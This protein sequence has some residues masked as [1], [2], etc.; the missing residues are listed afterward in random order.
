MMLFRRFAA[1]GLLLAVLSFSA[2]AQQPAAANQGSCAMPASLTISGQAN[3]FTDE[4]EEWLGDLIEKTFRQQF[5]VIEDPDGYLQKI[6]DRLLAQ[7]PPSKIHYRFYIVD[8]PELN[9]FGTVGG[10]IYLFRRVISFA[11]NEDE[12]AALLGHEI[13]HIATHQAAIEVSDFMR[14]LNVLKVGDRQDIANKWN[15]LVDNAAKIKVH[16]NEKQEQVIAD[17]VGLYAMARAGYDPNRAI[18]FLDRLF[19]TK[20]KTGGFWS[21]LFGRTSSDA[22]RL[23]EAMRNATAMSKNCIAPLPADSASAFANWQKS[24]VESK[25]SV[26]KEEVSG[27]LRKTSLNP[28]LRGDL[29][30]IHFSHDGA[31]IM[32][33]DES[34]IFLLTRD[35]LA[36]LFRIDAPDSSLAKFSPDMKSVVFYDK[37]YRVEKWDIPTQKRVS[38]HQVTLPMHCMQTTLSPT[39]DALAC[40]TNEFELQIIDVEKNSLAFSRKKF[41]QPNEFEAY[42]FE[43]LL[44]LG[45]PTEWFQMHFSPDG[46]YLVAGR[47]NT[48]LAYDLTTHSEVKLSGKTKNL[49]SHSFSFLGP[50][51]IAGVDYQGVKRKIMLA[52]F[53]TGETIGDVPAT[54]FGDMSPVAKGDYILMHNVGPENSSIGVLD[55]KT[56]TVLFGYKSPGFDIYDQWFAGESVGG[57]IGIFNMTDKKFVSHIRL[58]DSPLGYPRAVA[59]SS[60]GKW[61]ATS[62]PTR[63]AIWKLETGERMFYTLGFEG[64]FFDQD[65]FIGKFPKHEK[66]ASRVFQF[67]PND[68]SGKLLYAVSDD[69]ADTTAHQALPENFTWQL[70]ELLLSIGSDS[71]NRSA[72]LF[73]RVYDVRTKSKLWEHGLR[74]TRPEFFHSRAGKTLT[75]LVA[76]YSAIKAEAKD[77]PSLNARL[78]AIEGSEGKKDSY[79][80]RVFDSLTGKDLGA[81]LV[82]TGNLSFRVKWANTIKD[83]VLVGDSSNRTLV[84]SL[85]SG[86]QKGKVFGYPRAISNDA[87]KMLVEGNAGTAD[88]YDIATLAPLAHFTFPSRIINAE[89]TGDGTTLMVLTADQTVYQLKTEPEKEPAAEAAGA[90]K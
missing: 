73:L 15:Y 48:S 62:G 67:D 74:K 40:M 50:D 43:L 71:N 18:D 17:R 79:V 52:H 29:Q 20:R 28:Q 72:G 9:S 49:L 24:L 19:Q 36:N 81:V 88:L 69:P 89:F 31:Y 90:A 75:M 51:E 13:G 83:T 60:N 1:S 23:R 12:L 87:T 59:F 80:L 57:E 76:D 47:N 82:D 70:G 27:I 11:Q 25:F 42:F 6:A 86:K 16:D 54:T 41:Y 65:R 22:K 14:Q 26:R 32:A 10:H 35:P 63:G 45:G 21:D 77:D 53:P 46:R 38:V 55:K 58:P 8:G 56:G 34:S 30:S 61:L 2:H 68:N 3:M 66:T 33:Q 39:G 4:Q 78:Q 44:L 7:L 5:H 84:Y 64:A 37:E 85:Q